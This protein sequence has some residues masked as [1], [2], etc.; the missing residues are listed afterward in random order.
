VH[1][2]LARLLYAV[3]TESWAASAVA[4]AACIVPDTTIPGG[5]PTT[6]LPGLTPRSPVMMLEPVL[7]TVEPPRTAK[8]CAVPSDGAVWATA[9]E[10]PKS[11][12]TNPTL[13]T[14]LKQVR[15]IL[16]LPLK[17]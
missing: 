5:K 15:F 9:G 4:S 17:T 14:R 16:H 3:V 6:A 7:V 12:P 13:A 2:W 11:S 8:L 10:E 1:A